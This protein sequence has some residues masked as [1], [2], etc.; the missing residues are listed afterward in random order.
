MQEDKPKSMGAKQNNGD[1]TYFLQHTK[2]RA[3]RP[4]N[5]NG[6]KMAAYTG[7]LRSVSASACKRK[8][9]HDQPNAAT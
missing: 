8:I 5:I 4:A 2:V 6:M 7:A 9:H 1:L 3:A